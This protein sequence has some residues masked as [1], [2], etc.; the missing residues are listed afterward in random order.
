MRPIIDTLLSTQ[1]N[2]AKE[3]PEAAQENYS[4]S[5][6]FQNLK[7]QITVSELDTSRSDTGLKT[8]QPK[9]FLYSKKKSGKEERRFLF[10]WYNKWTWLHYDEAGD[11][12]YCIICK[13][14]TIIT[15]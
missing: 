12:V 15:C 13:Q 3:E 7:N 2:S 4:P 11:S 14:P 6:M 10:S 1:T 5:E 9:N 8:N